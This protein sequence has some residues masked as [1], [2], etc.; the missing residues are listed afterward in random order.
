M[1]NFITKVKIGSDIYDIMVDKITATADIE[2]GSRFIISDSTDHIVA[3]SITFDGSTTTKALSQAGTWIDVDNYELSIASSTELG[4]IKVGE[5]LDIDTETGLLKLKN[6]PDLKG[7]ATAVTPDISETTGT[8]IATVA[9]VKALISASDAMIF[10]G[11]VD[12]NSDLPAEHEAGWTYKVRTAGT[13]AGVVCEAGDMILCVADGESASNDDWAVIQT[14]IDGA[15]TGPASAV[16]GQIAVFDGTTGKVIIDSGLAVASASDLPASLEATANAGSSSKLARADHV[17]EK[18]RYGNIS[19]DGSIT[20]NAE[21]ANGDRIVIVDS[22][23]NSKLTGASIIFDGSTTTKA[24]AQSG[25]WIEVNNYELTPAT[26]TELG[27][28]IIGE[29]IF[30]NNQGLIA[31]SGVRGVATGNGANGTIEVNTNGTSTNVSVQG[32]S[33]AAFH[34]EEDFATSTHVH[35]YTTT[36]ASVITNV[37]SVTSSFITSWS[38]GV[39]PTAT[40]E[41]ETLI[42]DWGSLPELSMQV[43]QADHIT[44]STTTVVTSVGHVSG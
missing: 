23:D 3:S 30:V 11:I 36:D 7:N 39:L 40:V 22:S 27:G 16:D 13:Y 19:I 35:N 25:E 43:V 12:S 15:V 17:H 24:L 32:I 5:N 1:D 41:N 21:I 26:T 29:G 8:R 42:F 20:T 37:E 18:P 38:T 31:N 34:P 44:Y 28:V 33:T 14:N 9:Y 2:N 10:K 4:G 6:S